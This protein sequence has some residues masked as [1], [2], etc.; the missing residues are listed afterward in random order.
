MKT[1]SLK[2]MIMCLVLILITGCDLFHSHTYQSATCTKPKTCTECGETVGEALGHDYKE[3]TCTD[4]KICKICGHTEGEILGH[5]TDIGKCSKCNKYVNH[6]LVTKDIASEISKITTSITES[7]KYINQANYN[8]LSD[9]YIKFT[10][11][12]N[13]LVPSKNNLNKIIELCNDIKGLNN[14]KTKAQLTLNKFPNQVNGNSLDKLLKFLDEDEAYLKAWQD[15]LN[16]YQRILK[17]Y[18]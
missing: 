2:I 7:T 17:L 1:K 6:S 13:A 3:A 15:T 9:S 8:S 11:A 18:E 16:E 4:P 5:S 14:L 10:M 12:Y